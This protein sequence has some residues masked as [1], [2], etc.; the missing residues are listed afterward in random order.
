M[1]ETD[2]DMMVNELSKLMVDCGY[3]VNPPVNTNFL[4]SMMKVN[5]SKTDLPVVLEDINNDIVSFLKKQPD[6][7]YFLRKMDGF[8]F[9]GV[10]LYS[11]SLQLEED[12][13]PINNIFLYND[14]FR[15][16]DI[17]VSP[18]LSGCVVIG[19][20]GISFFTYDLVKNVFQIRGN[21]GAEKVFG[22]FYN[23]SDLLKE[24]LETVK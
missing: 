20:D 23:F 22:T 8:E 13:I 5:S 10:I 7:Y 1:M 16:N 9:D 15:N 21:V 4:E 3:R 6:Y 12:D 14:N 17:Y 24:I 18:D 11:F 19:Q 2:I